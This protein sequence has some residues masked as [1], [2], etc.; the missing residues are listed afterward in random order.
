MKNII[1]ILLISLGIYF[2]MKGSLVCK[3][4]KVIEYRYIPRTVKEEQQ[5]PVS[6]LNTFGYLFTQGI[7]K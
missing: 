6:T 2:I 1:I 7:L 4:E 5:D 3:N